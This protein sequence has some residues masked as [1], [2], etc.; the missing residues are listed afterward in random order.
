[1]KWVKT[2]Y[3]GIRFRESQSRKY[4]GKPDKYFVIRYQNSEKVEVQEPVGWASEDDLNATKVNSIRSELVHN[5]RMG[6]R[7]QSLKEQ[8]QMEMDDR[9][10]AEAE[11]IKIEAAQIAEEKQNVTFG[12]VAE[13]FIEWGKANKKSWKDDENRYNQRLKTPLG[14]LKIKDVSNAYIDTL[15][16]GWLK[17]VS[18][19]TVDHYLSLIHS[20]FEHAIKSL[21][22][23]IQNPIKDVKRPVYDN[24]KTRFFSHAQAAQLLEYL[25]KK[26]TMTTHDQT[27]L[28]LYAGLRFSEIAK[29]KWD[30]INLDTGLIEIRNTKTHLNRQAYITAPIEKMFRRRMADGAKDPVYVFRSRNGKQQKHVS[31]HFY[32][33]MDILGFNSPGMSRVDTFDF[34]STR[35]TFAS[36]LAST[37]ISLYEIMALMGHQ[38][39]SQTQRYAKLLPETK[40]RAVEQLVKA[41]ID[42]TTADVIDIKSAK[43]A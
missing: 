39:I 10:K 34:H 27:I 32:R 7:P 6:L 3:P 4:Q 5:I 12:E 1:M 24:K 17:K 28:G 33:A 26:R 38:D 25:N 40:R 42:Q 18:P 30:D 11:K 22:I 31:S 14:R 15:K 35:H 41:S 19:K 43:A 20:I 23:E 13:Q 21:K 37:G 9:A 16:A 8:R 29:L 2:I 36:W